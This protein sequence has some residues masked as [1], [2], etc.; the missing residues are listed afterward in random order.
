[1]ICPPLEELTALSACFSMWKTTEA[2]EK[3]KQN[4]HISFQLVNR[5]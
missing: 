2:E 4:K 3:N 1:M 5:I